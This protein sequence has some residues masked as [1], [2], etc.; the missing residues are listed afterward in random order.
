MPKYT[1]AVQFFL[2]VFFVYDFC[3]NQPPGGD[4]PVYVSFC[5]RFSAILASINSVINVFKSSARAA[6]WGRLKI[7]SPM[8]LVLYL[9]VIHFFKR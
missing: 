8:T 3:Q 7:S 9:W 1:S 4:R 2:L 6:S 5:W